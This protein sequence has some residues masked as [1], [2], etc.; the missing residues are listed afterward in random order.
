MKVF[1]IIAILLLAVFAA[2]CA[3]A[4][5]VGLK[6][7]LLYDA[8]LSPTVGVEVGVAPKWTVDL[9]GTLNA[10]TVND[11]RWKQWMVQPEGRYWFCQRFAG[12]FVAAHAL[13]GQFN[14]GNIDADFKFL[15]TDFSKLKDERYQGWMA[16]AG[17][18]YGYSWILNRNWNIEAELGIGWVYSRYDVYRCAD[19]G[20]KIRENES[21]NYFG[22]TKVAVNL[23]Y[24]F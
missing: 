23:I 20:K 7:N 3:K 6:T 9:S 5:N 21:H 14:F 19:C 24:V 11:H 12:H 1:H 18:A 16:G 15:G 10:W 8:L 2:P 22:P 13:G 17:V 4:Q